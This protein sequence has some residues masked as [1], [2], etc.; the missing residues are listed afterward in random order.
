MK[1]SIL[2]ILSISF[3]FG[4]RQKN[5]DLTHVFDKYY[6]RILI[7]DMGDFKRTLDYLDKCVDDSLTQE[8]KGNILEVHK[9]QKEYSDKAFAVKDTSSLKLIRILYFD[10]VKKYSVHKREEEKYLENN[11]VRT[12]TLEESKIIA[13]IDFIILEK[14]VR[15]NIRRKYNLNCLESKYPGSYEYPK[16]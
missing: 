4:C 13:L 10:A 14:N 15:T 9:I 12:N 11:E 3:L 8:V 7:D 16:N 6:S 2:I 1:Q 5:K